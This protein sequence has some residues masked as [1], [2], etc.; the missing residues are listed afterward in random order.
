MWKRRLAVILLIVALPLFISGLL[1]LAVF[2]VP[3]LVLVFTLFIR[4][5]K[6]E[7]KPLF[8][9]LKSAGYSLWLFIPKDKR[10]FI[11]VPLFS[12]IF[13]NISLL[14]VKLIEITL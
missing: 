11:F 13:V 14:I 10:K 6:P 7:D 9:Q 3:F 4:R 12:L 5:I 2:I 8:A 1:S